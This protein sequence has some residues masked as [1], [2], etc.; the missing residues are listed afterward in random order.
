MGIKISTDEIKYIGL[1]ESMTGATVKDCI[2]EDNKNK[3]VYVVKEGDMGLAIGKNG[4]NAQRVKETLNKPI[5][6]IEYSDDPVKFIKNI[7]WPVKV[8]SIHVSERKDGKKIAVLDINKKDKGLVIGKE[9][10]NIDRIKNLLK[11][12]HN[13]DDI[14]I[15]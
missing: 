11:R 1:F 8:K 4:A 3:I 14:M 6:I 2:F 7:I 9:G 13:L 10:K 15:M 12:H 5:D